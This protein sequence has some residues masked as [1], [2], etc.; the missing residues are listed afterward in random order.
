VTPPLAQFGLNLLFTALLGLVILFP[1]SA[2]EEIGWRGYLLPRMIQARAPQPILLTSLI[3]GAWHLPII[4]LGVYAKGPSVW[5]SA[6]GIMVTAL[7]VGPL[8][9]WVRLGT[10]SIWAAIIMHDAWNALI[11]A[12]FTFATAD[13]ENNLW[14]GEQGILVV[15][16]LIVA[17]LVI[18]RSWKPASLSAAG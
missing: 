7:V 6:A 9:A 15:A 17:V 16:T 11:N 14:I 4:F 13:R 18:R 10:G 1:P 5:L 8:L 12:G 2:G 3:W